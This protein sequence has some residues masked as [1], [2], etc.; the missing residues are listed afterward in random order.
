[1]VDPSELVACIRQLFD[2]LLVAIGQGRM[3]IDKRQA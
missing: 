2:H 1:M 3:L